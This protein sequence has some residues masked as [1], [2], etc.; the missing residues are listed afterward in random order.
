MGNTVG[1]RGNMLRP[2]APC[3][4]PL[5]FKGI[6]GSSRGPCDGLLIC[7]VQWETQ[8]AC[9]HLLR[10]RFRSWCGNSHSHLTDF[11][12]QSNTISDATNHYWSEMILQLKLW[13][14]KNHSPPQHVRIVSAKVWPCYLVVTTLSGVNG[15][16]N[17]QAGG[18]LSSHRSENQET[19]Q[20]RLK[21]IQGCTRIQVM[22]TLRMCCLSC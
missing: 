5:L 20:E 18:I 6:Q 8:C 15:M 9:Y 1:L 7:L 13:K 11:Q 3:S 21:D 17:R 22:L 2:K 10:T 19:E 16:R 14:D 4:I 12:I